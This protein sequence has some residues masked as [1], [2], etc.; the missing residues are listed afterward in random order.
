MEVIRIGFLGAGV[1]ASAIIEGLVKSGRFSPDCILASDRSGACSEKMAALGAKSTR[2]NVELV[3]NSDVIIIGTKPD[4]IPTVL[5]DIVSKMDV[6]EFSTKS[7]I[8]IAA[9]VPIASIEGYLPPNT[10]SVI[11][12]MPNTP[13]AVNECAAAFCS[14]TKTDVKD[15]ELCSKI[16]SAVGTISEVPEKAMDGVTG[17]SGSGPAYIFMIIE[18]LADG[19]VRA[20]LPRAVAMQ[21]AA[22]TVKGAAVM[23]QESGM[24][25]GALKDKVCSP[26]G[27]TIAAV[28]ALEKGGLRS[29]IISGVMASATRS[30]EMR[31]AGGGGAAAA[32]KK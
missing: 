15:K 7:F 29:T 3:K 6:E 2:D 12:V 23:V 4:G 24:H 22:Q 9:G 21:L 28:E 16:F 32:S 18:A 14:G 26:G 13:C 8:S 5:Q 17:V 25:P 31:G 20:G 19:G 11:R 10:K 30:A 1:M 27:T